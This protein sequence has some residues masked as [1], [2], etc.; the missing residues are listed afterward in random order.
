MTR[1]IC[2]ILSLWQQDKIFLTFNHTRKVNTNVAFG[3]E[4]KYLQIQTSQKLSKFEYIWIPQTASKYWGVL[5]TQ[6]DSCDGTSIWKMENHF[7]D[8]FII[9]FTL[10]IV[11]L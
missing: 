1:Q 7:F 6:S 9:Y 10:T 8:L 5:K 11:I 2:H 4:V 3:F